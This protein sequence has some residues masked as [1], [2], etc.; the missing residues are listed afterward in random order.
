MHAEYKT[1]LQKDGALKTARSVVMEKTLKTSM[2]L[3]HYSTD[4]KHTTIEPIM[5]R[6][7]EH[8]LDVV[9]G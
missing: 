7:G 9:P 8:G 4:G 3:V 2:S 1:R 6:K 5:A